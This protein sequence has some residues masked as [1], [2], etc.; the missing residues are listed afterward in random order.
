MPLAVSTYP[1]R[2]VADAA[3]HAAEGAPLPTLITTEAAAVPGTHPRPRVGEV[4]MRDFGDVVGGV[5]PE[6]RHHY[7]GSAED[8]SHRARAAGGAGES[9]GGGI[10]EQR[11]DGRERRAR[12][13]G[14]EVQVGSFGDL[15]RAV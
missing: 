2:L 1:S 3:T 11:G 10:V 9:P 7:A 14:R 13:G 4:Q 12:S 6:K 15:R 8:R 5:I